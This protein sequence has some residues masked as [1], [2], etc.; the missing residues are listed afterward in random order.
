MLRKRKWREKRKRNEE[1]RR[2]EEGMRK[3]W[4]EIRKDSKVWE[5]EQFHM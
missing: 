1:G 3:E 5:N 4:E 2:K